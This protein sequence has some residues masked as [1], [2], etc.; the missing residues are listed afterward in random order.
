M[1]S[2]NYYVPKYLWAPEGKSF[3]DKLKEKPQEEKQAFLNSLSDNE[4]EALYYNWKAWARPKQLPPPDNYVDNPLGWLYWLYF[5]GRGQGKTR[6]SAE[7][8]KD[9][10]MSGKCKIGML[11]G[12]TFKEV[13]DVMIDGESGLMSVF[14]TDWKI[15]KNKTSISFYNPKGKR[16]AV[17]YLFS[18]EE[19]ERVRGHQFDTVWIDELA[20]FRYLDKFWERFTA[21][22]RLGKPK[23]ILSTTPKANMNR[24]NLL[25][26][27]RLVCTKGRSE[28]NAHN[29]SEGWYDSMKA[30][31]SDS[32][33]AAQEL[34]GELYLDESGALFKQNWINANRLKGKL[35]Y[36]DSSKKFS[37]QIPG[38]DKDV[39]LIRFM[40]AVDPSGSSKDSACEC[41]I[42][43][44]A[45]GSDGY[46]YQVE[47]ASFRGPPG[48][49]AA[50]A[51][52]LA[53]KYDATI[54]YETN[55]GGEMVDNI[56]RRAA[57]D[58]GIKVK[59]DDVR[60]VKN[61]YERA[62]LVSPLVQKGR[63][64]FLGN[65]FHALE[66]QM[67]GWVPDGSDKSPD[68]MDAFVWCFIRL[69]VKDVP[70][71]NPTNYLSF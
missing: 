47:D 31:L 12:P 42:N 16:V 62:S 17:A 37:L 58:K 13:R 19:Y 71:G 1:N 69:M 29:V 35:I 20:A 54:C 60:A 41:G 63:I 11:A 67:T 6:T 49:W 18:G 57:R 8:F 53:E 40:V 55:F 32:D 30:S 7:F 3:I 39:S 64:K 56:L 65:R 51:I 4:K 44:G 23:V 9:R 70:R 21:T 10:V 43:V 33:F 28:E 24:I 46:G 36:D 26:D 34:D 68:R 2:E 66:K 5:G 50:K 22:L 48:D 59:L 14:P 61:K 52:E 38:N 45:L 15:K 27:D 25:N